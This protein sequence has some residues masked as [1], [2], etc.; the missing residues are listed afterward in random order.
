LATK[1]RAE[2]S[3]LEANHRV[4][5]RDFHCVIDK[6]TQSS[7][8]ANTVGLPSPRTLFTM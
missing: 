4:Y 7:F 5:D 6:I 1:R 2:K 8:K 3:G